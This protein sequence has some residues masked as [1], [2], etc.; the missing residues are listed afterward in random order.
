IGP[1]G[2]F[3]DET[4]HRRDFGPKQA[5][6]SEN[7][8]PTATVGQSGAFD[9]STTHINDYRP[10]KGERTESF[11]PAS[12]AL[13]SGEFDGT[14]TSKQDYTKKSVEPCPVELLLRNGEFNGYQ[15]MEQANG[16]HWYSKQQTGNAGG[17]STGHQTR[18]SASTSVGDHSQLPP[19]G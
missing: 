9:G 14:T 13:Q 2:E 18:T 4:T 3:T 16:H 19:V 10:W 11:K 12:R 6:R 7:F 8:K 17:P 5:E 1:Q 15:K